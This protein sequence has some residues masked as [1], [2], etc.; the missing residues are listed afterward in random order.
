M[1][2]SVGKSLIREA[3]KDRTDPHIGGRL[4][5]VAPLVLGRPSV[6]EAGIVR[7]SMVSMEPNG[8]VAL[9]FH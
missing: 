4:E 2:L 1:T 9:Q 7:V 6:S 3:R 5:Q 8:C